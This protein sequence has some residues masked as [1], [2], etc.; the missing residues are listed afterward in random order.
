MPIPTPFHDRTARLCTSYRWIDWAGYLAVCS[1]HLPNDSEY[2]ALRH[3]AGLIDITPL[4]KYEISGPDAAAYLSRIMTKNIEALPVG[5][6]AY[7]CWCDDFGKIIDD[8][9]VF[10]LNQDRLRVHTAEPMLAW[11]EQFK[12]GFKITLEDMTS[13]IAAVA[14]QGPT[15]RDILRQV[16]GDDVDDLPYYGMMTA[17]ATVADFPQRLYRR[18][19]I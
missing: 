3:A 2:Y 11:F 18:F 4:F 13:K 16:A 9:T 7:S 17:E 10:R 19:R 8:G 15:S 6:A 5:R 1:Y 14:I 12:R